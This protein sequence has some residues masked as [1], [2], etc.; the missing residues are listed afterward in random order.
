MAVVLLSGG[1]ITPMVIRERAW[2]EKPGHGV[3]VSRHMANS[4]GATKCEGARPM[5]Y[6]PSVQSPI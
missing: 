6:D 1:Y 3:V 4:V 5:L 2:R